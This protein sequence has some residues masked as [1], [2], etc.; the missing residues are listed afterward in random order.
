[1]LHA[2]IVLGATFGWLVLFSGVMVVI[3][4]SKR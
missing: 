2:L 1:M 3:G 4:D